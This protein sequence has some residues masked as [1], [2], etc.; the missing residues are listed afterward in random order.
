M[1]VPERQIGGPHTARGE[2]QLRRRDHLEI[3]DAR[4]G[5]GDARDRLGE[6]Q[7]A[8]LASLE[9]EV[10]DRA[11]FALDPDGRDRAQPWL[12]GRYGAARSDHHQDDNDAAGDCRPRLH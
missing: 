9:G 7:Q 11:H 3:G 6:D 4:I 8:V 10:S 12:S 5:D 2:Q 1:L